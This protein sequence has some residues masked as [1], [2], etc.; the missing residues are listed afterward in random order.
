MRKTK[1]VCTIGPASSSDKKIE[2]LIRA[3][4]NV[5][6][7]NFSHGSYTDHEA[8]YKR[9]R[10]ASDLTGRAVG[11]LADLQ[12]PKIRL[13]TFADGPVVAEHLKGEQ[14]VVERG[15]GAAPGERGSETWPKG[16]QWRTGGGSVWVTGN[17]DPETN[18]SFWGTGNGGPWDR[19]VR[20]PQGGDNLF[21]ASILYLP[22]LFTAMVLDG[23]M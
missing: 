20:S 19:N 2:Q 14:P 4:M 10:A 16:E 21:L 17:Y 8:H 15:S 22:V 23:R 18:T 11:V 13:G 5:A 6:R 7:L 9:V 1:I 3:G 12:G